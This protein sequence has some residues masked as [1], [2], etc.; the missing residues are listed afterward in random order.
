MDEEDEPN[1]E[2]S[3]SSIVK[4]KVLIRNLTKLIKIHDTYQCPMNYAEFLVI[5]Y[6][7]NKILIFF[8][9]EN[10]HS[11]CHRILDRLRA[12]QSVKQHIEQFVFP[13][14]EEHRLDR[15][16]MLHAYIKV[17]KGKICYFLQNFVNLQELAGANRYTKS[18]QHGNNTWDLL[19]L[20]IAE[21]ITDINMRCQAIIE[22][23]NGTMPPWSQQLT[24]VIKG[25]FTT[26]TDKIDPEL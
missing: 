18:I 19:C 22:I 11:I 24:N 26:Q 7:R 10:V 1:P 20:Q 4:L 12:V 9:S 5:F 3:S 16:E 13:Y 6:S 21:Q 23:A 17:K 14:I 2:N 25:M 8:Q 15:N